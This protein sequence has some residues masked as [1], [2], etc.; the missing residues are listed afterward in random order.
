[1]RGY[2]TPEYVYRAGVVWRQ[3]CGGGSPAET[4]A[5][6]WGKRMTC[7]ECEPAAVQIE[8]MVAWEPDKYRWMAVTPGRCVVYEYE[9]AA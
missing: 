5:R 1:M 2:V 8:N 4:Q 7:R 9:E 3:S 6:R